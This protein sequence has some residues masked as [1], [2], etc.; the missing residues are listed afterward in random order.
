MIDKYIKTN[1][2][3]IKKEEDSMVHY[4]NQLKQAVCEEICKQH[5]STMETAE[6]YNVPLKTVEKW[7]TAYNKDSEYFT[8]KTDVIPAAINKTY[9]SKKAERAFKKYGDMSNAELQLE[10]LARDVELAR[11]KKGYMVR[12]SGG[13]L[14]YGTF[15]S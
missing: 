10:L 9:Q 7:V 15:S 6:H 4:T 13:K 12:K 5:N 8:R 2:I 1:I 3:F 14:E 11:L